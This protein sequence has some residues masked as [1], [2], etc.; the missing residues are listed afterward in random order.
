LHDRLF[1]SV[2]F[3]LSVSDPIWIT[4]LGTRCTHLGVR[5]TAR[6]QFAAALMESDNHSC[7]G[8]LYA[9]KQLFLG[10]FFRGFDRTRYD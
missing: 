6:L 7:Q 8:L 1:V 9:P 10:I 4:I 5:K 3:S 2:R